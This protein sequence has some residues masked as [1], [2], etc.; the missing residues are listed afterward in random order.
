MV[1]RSR[2]HFKVLVEERHGIVYDFFVASGYKAIIDPDGYY[3][4]CLPL[5]LEINAGVGCA[6]NQ[7]IR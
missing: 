3:E 5:I 6:S 4:S 2:G 1:R 7:S